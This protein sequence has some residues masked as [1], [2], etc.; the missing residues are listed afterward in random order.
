[1]SGHA[2]RWRAYLRRA[3][4]L[5]PDSGQSRLPD[6]AVWNSSCHPELH[7][8]HPELNVEVLEHPELHEDRVHPP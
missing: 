2:L 8:R 7:G 1:M 3:A 5:F 6:L 4:P